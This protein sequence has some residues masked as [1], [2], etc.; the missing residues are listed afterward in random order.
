VIDLECIDAAEADRRADRGQ[1]PIGVMLSGALLRQE[2]ARQPVSGWLRHAHR[3]VV[4]EGSDEPWLDPS[5]LGAARLRFLSLPFGPRSFDRALAWLAASGRR[6]EPDRRS[7]HRF[8]G[9]A[10]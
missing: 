6:W 10:A 7:G 2:M 4:C 3:I 1:V 5:R 9:P 8:T